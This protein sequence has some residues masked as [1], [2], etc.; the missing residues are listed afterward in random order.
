MGALCSCCQWLQCSQQ[1]GEDGFMVSEY[2]RQ[3]Q[4]ILFLCLLCLFCRVSVSTVFISIRCVPCLFGY[5][6]LGL[7][8][9]KGV[10]M[11][12][13]FVMFT[14]RISF[15]CIHKQSTGSLPA[16]QQQCI[17]IMYYIIAFMSFRGWSE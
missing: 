9:T 8:A 12:K 15:F 7:I 10:K 5:M 1:D 13:L 6:P 17:S 11:T 4:L 3:L 14:G 2:A 16:D